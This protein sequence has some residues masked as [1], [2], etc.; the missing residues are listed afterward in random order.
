MK[1][2]GAATRK[3]DWDEVRARLAQA[4]VRTEQALALTPEAARSLMEKRA[5]ALAHR[6]ESEVIRGIRLP[7]Q[8]R[9]GELL[10]LITFGIVGE[11]YAIETHFVREVMPF[12]ESTPLPGAPDIL[13]GLINVRSEILPLFD[14][15][16]FLGTAPTAAAARAHIIVLGGETPAFGL[17]AHTVEEVTFLDIEEVMEPPEHSGGLSRACVRGVTRDALL[18]LDGAELLRDPQ[19]VIDQSQGTGS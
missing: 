17:L 7:G 10:N 18:L 6:S 11:R 12:T 16:R 4:A 9:M 15:R 14:L 1:R 2:R 5:R 3:I 19:L 13:I 8:P